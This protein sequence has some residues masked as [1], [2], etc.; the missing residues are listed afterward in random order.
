[1]ADLISCSSINNDLHFRRHCRNPGNAGWLFDFGSWFLLALGL[2]MAHATNNLLND[3]TDYSR[4]V[5]Q[6]NY[7]R[8]QYGPQPL[9]HGLMTKRELLT[10]AALTGA[11]ALAAG[12]AGRP[13]DWPM[14]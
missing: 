6:D 3:F 8:S 1:M 2:I 5:D 10:Y 7:Y 11:I 9:V 4:G 12:L 13:G 14:L